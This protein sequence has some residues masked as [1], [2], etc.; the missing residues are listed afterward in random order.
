MTSG[1][2]EP[3]AAAAGAAP[4]S[5]VG[6]GKRRGDRDRSARTHRRPTPGQAR[7]AGITIRISM[8]PPITRNR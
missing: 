3:V 5:D 2:W 4:A 6:D 1:T 8:I 7:I